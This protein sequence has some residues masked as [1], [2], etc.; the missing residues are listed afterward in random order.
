MGGEGKKRKREEG[1]ESGVKREREGEVLTY[2]PV[3]NGVKISS[4]KC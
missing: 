1:K 4:W 3:V 2:F